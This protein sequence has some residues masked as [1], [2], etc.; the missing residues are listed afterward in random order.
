L[1]VAV[2]WQPIATAPEDGT[3]VFLYRDGWSGAPIGKYQAYPG[4]P[5]IGAGGEACYMWGWM[6]EDEYLGLGIEDGWLGWVDDP[7]PTHW[8]PLPAAPI[9]ADR[10]QPAPAHSAGDSTEGA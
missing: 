7:T 5:V 1:G 4:N 3:K 6:L 8:Q 10:P 2:S 9:S